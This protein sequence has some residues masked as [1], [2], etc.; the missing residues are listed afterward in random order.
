MRIVEANLNLRIEYGHRKEDYKIDKK[1]AQ[2][3]CGISPN[4]DVLAM[5]EYMNC[6]N[7]NFLDCLTKSGYDLFSSLDSSERGIL[8]AVKRG[9]KVVQREKKSYP[10]MIHLEI[11]S[12]EGTFDLICLRILTG[13]RCNSQEFEDRRKQFSEI[14]AYI[15]SLDIH[16]TIIVGDFNNAKI[17]ENYEGYAQERYNYQWIKNE[18]DDISLELQYI[19]GYSHQGY[20]KEDHIILSKNMIAK[21]KYDDTLFKMR[22]IIGYPDHVPLVADVNLNIVA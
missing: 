16:R 10:H 3:L 20:L 18:F 15:S 19:N 8:I 5:V 11:T 7:K 4:P 22:N 6:D 14:Y 21:S 13:K 1:I 17:R 2:T 12:S 9:I